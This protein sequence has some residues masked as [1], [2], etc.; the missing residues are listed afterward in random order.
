MK[1]NYSID[2]IKFCFALSIALSHFSSLENGRLF[3][4]INDGYLVS[5]FF[6]LS[7]FFLVSSF[8]SGKYADAGSYTMKRVN[9]IYP[10]YI[11]AFLAL[12]SFYAI[13]G[14]STVPNVLLDLAESLPEIFLLQ[15]V[16]IFTGGINYPLWQICCLIVVSHFLFSL[17]IWN[18][19]L[20][21]N[22]ICPVLALGTVIYFANS[23]G[24]GEVNWW[25]IEGAVFYMPL[26]R[27]A[28]YVSL[29]MVVHTPVLRLVNMLE[30]N[31]S[32]FTPAL[33]SAGSIV[34][35]LL[36]WVN[37]KSHVGFI[38]FCLLLVCM[39]YSKSFYSK[40]LNFSLLSRLEKLSL[41]YYFNQ[42]LII[43]IMPKIE[44][45]TN[46]WKQ[47]MLDLVFVVLLTVYSVFVLYIVDLIMGFVAKR[48]ATAARQ[49]N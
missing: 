49:M 26:V 19:Q 35:L 41:G 34:M 15:N 40:Y 25:G 5:L 11:F 43:E 2:I 17:L 31:S 13:T 3:P 30:K 33:V 23:N 20:S 29:G 36:F 37:R 12:F 10:Y 46:G 7:G 6:V 45:L 18:R 32:R 16:G 22:L 28:G 9:R 14:R 21:L 27:A 24:A 47:R 38:P 4:V 44:S 39:L 1:R 42:A 48:R 8:D